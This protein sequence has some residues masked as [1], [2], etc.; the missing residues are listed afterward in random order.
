MSTTNW[1]LD[2]THSTVGFTVRH[3]VIAKVRGRFGAFNGTIQLDEADFTKSRVAVTIETSSIDTGVG[4]R[5][6]HL[7][8]GDFFDVVNH[9][10]IRFE[11]TGIEKK[12]DEDYAVHGNLTI[13]GV[14]KP[15]VLAAEFGGKGTDPWGN[16]RVGFTAK[17]SIARTDFG[18]K[19]NQALEAGGVLVGEKVEIE[20]DV[21]AVK[22]K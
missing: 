5:D 12:S 10:Q 16:A 22:A 3:M 9:P 20:L 15:V 17:T 1:N 13:R 2:T 6:N 14:T 19:W 4:D 7:R 18:L 21:Q 11:S 8:S